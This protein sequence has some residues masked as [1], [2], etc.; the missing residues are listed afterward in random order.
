MAEVIKYIVVC[1]CAG[2]PK[3]VAF[4]DDSRPPISRT[5]RRIANSS[6]SSESMV[7]MSRIRGA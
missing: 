6:R 7:S 1:T 4:I 2:E 5:M 3:A